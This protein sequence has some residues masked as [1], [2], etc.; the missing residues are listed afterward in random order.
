VIYTGEVVSNQDPIRLGRVKV[1]VTEFHRNR[2]EKLLPWAFVLSRG[3]GTYDTGSADRFPVHAS[4]YVA[5]ENN[6][7][8]RPVVL[9]G[10][11]KIV[12]AAQAYGETGEEWTA[13]WLVWCPT[14]DTYFETQ[15]EVCPTCNRK[16][17]RNTDLAQEAKDKEGVSVL[18]KLPKGATMFVDETDEEER[19]VIV[20][21]AGQVFEM[22]SPVLEA[23]NVANAARRGIS[24][25]TDGTGLEYAQM[26]GP[27][28]IRMMDLSGNIL[29]LYSE[30]GEEKV[31]VE[32][33]AFGNFMEM[34]KTGIVL[35]ALEGV[36]NEGV[37][38]QITASGLKVNGKYLV[39][40]ELVDWL[41]QYKQTIAQS[42]QPGSPEPLYPAALS[43]LTTKS[44]QSMNIEGMKTK[45]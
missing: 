40:E 37:T 17:V 22:V 45:L 20:D 1:R 5:F 25:V 2:D 6:N 31:R 27:S 9:G 32:N 39:T 16:T 15:V 35:Q 43:D 26:S 34:T 7:P 12:T 24:M 18:W 42:T 8:Q 29:L 13:E 10:A 30:D 38:V 21:R 23:E 41:M 14:C 36:D 3:G 4:V 11:G 44:G 19:L 28:Y 33:A